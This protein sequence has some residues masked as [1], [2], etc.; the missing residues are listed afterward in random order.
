MAKKATTAAPKA[1]PR[2]KAAPKKVSVGATKKS[3]PAASTW[4]PAA[5]WPAAQPFMSAQSFQPFMQGQPSMKAFEQIE[6]AFKSFQPQAGSVNVEETINQAKEQMEKFGLT[7]FKGYEDAA[8]SSKET[9]EAAVKSSQ[10]FAEGAKEVGKAISEMTQS[11]LEMSMQAG[12]AML[13][14]KTFKDFMDLQSDFAKK[15]FDQMI[16]GTS[17]VSDLAVKVANEAFEPLA[18][19]VNET[20]EKVSKKA[21]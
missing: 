14:V 20:I 21:A 6:A 15:S 4:A 10:L 17:K 2:A 8:Q 1:A 16:A 7:V 3:Q 5:S 19:R 9:V 12:Q 13:G 18:Q 11:S